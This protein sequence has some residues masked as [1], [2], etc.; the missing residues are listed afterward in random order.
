MAAVITPIKQ[1]RVTEPTRVAEE[2]AK[3]IYME[4]EMSLAVLRAEL[5]QLKMEVLKQDGEIARVHDSQN[6]ARLVLQKEVHDLQLDMAVIIGR[7]KNSG[8]L[9]SVKGQCRRLFEMAEEA[10]NRHWKLLVLLSSG[11]G[12]GAAIGKFLL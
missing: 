11:V 3:E 2:V 1:P 4:S 6:T 8:V 12:S 9:Y 5:D 7:D 10:K